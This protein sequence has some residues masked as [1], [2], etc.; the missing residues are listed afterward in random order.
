MSASARCLITGSEDEIEKEAGAAG[1]SETGG[2]TYHGPD[3][4][5]DHEWTVNMASVG[6]QLDDTIFKTNPEATQT[7][8][9]R[10]RNWWHHHQ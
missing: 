2:I 8:A 10:P 5:H 3:R 1:R 7:I 4:G 9:L 6:S